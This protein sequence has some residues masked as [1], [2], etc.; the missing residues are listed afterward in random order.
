MWL[1]SLIS[2]VIVVNVST[3]Q[4][5]V[6]FPFFRSGI[7]NI[8]FNLIYCEPQ[9]LQA[10]LNRVTRKCMHFLILVLSF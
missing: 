8:Q 4:Y 5:K 1:Y 10:I 2:Y 7:T 6:L 9:R 3:K